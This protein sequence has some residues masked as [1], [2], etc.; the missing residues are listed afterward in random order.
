MIKGRGPQ[1]RAE[2]GDQNIEAHHR[3]QVPVSEG[4]VIAEITEQQ[5][6]R[7]G[8]HTRHNKS[9]S[10]TPAQRAKEIRDHYKNRAK[11]IDEGSG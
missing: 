10:L 9:S 2:H 4:G 1:T 3:D 6:C 5:H 11:K 7:D 8:N